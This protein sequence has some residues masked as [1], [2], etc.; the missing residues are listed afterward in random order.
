M[1][2]RLLQQFSSITL[3]Q[4]VHPESIPPPGWANSEGTNGRERIWLDSRI[5]L[6]VRVRLL[7]SSGT[8][9]YVNIWQ[10]GLWVKMDDKTEGWNT[11]D[12]ILLS[13]LCWMMT[14]VIRIC[15]Y[16]I[17]WVGTLQRDPLCTVYISSTPGT[18]FVRISIISNAT[19]SLV[20]NFAHNERTCKSINRR[21]FMEMTGVKFHNSLAHAGRLKVVLF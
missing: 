7:S 4:E 20:F 3:T 5:I 1:L 15:L 14:F 13:N 17:T 21:W 10:G 2:I 8:L 11:F 16:S 18:L 9:L 6:Y 12:V 19:V